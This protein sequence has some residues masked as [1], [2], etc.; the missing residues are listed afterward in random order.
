MQLV[1]TLSFSSFSGHLFEQHQRIR[2]P[3]WCCIPFSRASCSLMCHPLLQKQETAYLPSH[4]VSPAPFVFISTTEWS[5]SSMPRMTSTLFPSLCHSI[6]TT[7]VPGVGGL[8]EVCS[9]YETQRNQVFP[10]HVSRPACMLWRDAATAGESCNSLW[11]GKS[12][13]PKCANH[14]RSHLFC[15]VSSCL[16]TVLLSDITVNVCNSYITL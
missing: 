6:H 12:E 2:F 3:A 9:L 11:R 15:S 7:W 13:H 8:W 14:V 16:P 5:H 4:L 1:V 10:G